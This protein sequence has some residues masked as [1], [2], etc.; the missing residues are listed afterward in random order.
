MLAWYV[1]HPLSRNGVNF[2][3]GIGSDFSEISLLAA[4]LVALRHHQCHV[5][6]CWRLG[7]TDSA[8][9]APACKHHH[10]MRKARGRT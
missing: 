6:R 2:W 5:G 8:V 10:S 4:V 1:L 7:H 9:Q 3:G